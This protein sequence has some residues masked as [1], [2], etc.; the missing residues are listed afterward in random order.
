MQRWSAESPTLY[1]LL[2]TLSDADGHQLE[3]VA[4]R[5][6]FREVVMADGNFLVNGQPIK[7]KGVNRHDF[8]PD[9]GRAVTV[10]DMIDDILLMKRHNINSVRTAHYPNRPEFYDLCDAYG[11]YVM[12]ECDLETHGFGYDGDDIPTRVPSWRA[13]F[14]DRMQ[15][16][17]ERDK[18]HACVVMWSLGNEAGFGPNH[19][20]MA[21]WAHRADPTRPIHY[22]QDAKA[23]VADVFSMMYASIDHVKKEG[24]TKSEKPFIL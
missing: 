3:A 5:I 15:R 11:L 4:L 12:D 23:E 16:T 9:R 19:V 13:A 7:F 20:A 8:H 24:R 17:V 14:V 21:D 22:E 10:Q 1:T 6:G 18:N 2:L